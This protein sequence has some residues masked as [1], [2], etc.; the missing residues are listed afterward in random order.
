MLSKKQHKLQESSKK[1]FRPIETTE[2]TSFALYLDSLRLAIFLDIEAGLVPL[3]LCATIGTTATT[4]VDPLRL[5]CDV[6]NRYGLWVD[7]DAAYA[8][9]ACICPEFQHFLDGLEG[10]HSF[11]L[12]AHKWFFTPLDCCCL[13]LKDPKALPK[14]LTTNPEFLMTSN[15]EQVVEYKDWQIT[16]S[17]RFR[18]MKLWLVLRSY[19]V[20]NL[21]SF[22]RSHVKMAQI[23]EELVVSDK[24][25]EFVVP[26]NFAMVCFRALPLAMGNKVYDNGMAQKIT[27]DQHDQERNNQLNQELLKSINA[28]GHVY[29]THAVV[30]GLYIIRFAVGATLTEDRHVFTAWKVVQEHLD[31]IIAIY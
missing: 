23:F 20:D 17:L 30:G 27:Y 1:N 19:G 5:L 2:S 16:L 31:A 21:R 15:S 10:A 7:V 9:N 6:A 14:S 22:L 29:M 26:R 12:N 28:S 4:A 24:R 11:S 25:F 18:S 3:F 8:G 13:W